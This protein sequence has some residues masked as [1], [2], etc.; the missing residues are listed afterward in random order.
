[1]G[2]KYKR[3]DSGV[4][5]CKY[6]GSAEKVIIPARIENLPVKYIGDSVFSGCFDLAEVKIPDSVEFIGGLAFVSC[7][8]PETIYISDFALS[9]EEIKRIVHELL[10]ENSWCTVSPIPK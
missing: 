5:I 4:R 3:I 10:R 8:N 2:F 1:M 9:R 7:I 6:R